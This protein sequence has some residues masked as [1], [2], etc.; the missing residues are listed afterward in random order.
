MSRGRLR[1]AVVVMG[2]AGVLGV[3]AMPA[4]AAT[5]ATATVNSPSADGAKVTATTQVSVTVDRG[6][7][8]LNITGPGGYGYAQSVGTANGTQTVTCTFDPRS[9]GC[10]TG[11][12]ILPN[13]VYTVTASSKAYSTSSGCGTLQTQSCS[14]AASSSPGRTFLLS[15]APAA[16]SGVTATATSS[17]DIRIAWS[18][19]DEPD[20][21]SYDLL[22]GAGNPLITQVTC[23]GSD[24]HVDLSYPDDDPGGDKDFRVRAWRS[25]GAGDQVKSA[26]SSTA[27]VSLPAPSTAGSGGTGGTDGGTSG[28]DPGTGGTGGSGGGSTGGSTSGGS[29]GGSGGIVDN[30]T[31]GGGTGTSGPTYS[32]YS[33]RPGLGLK[34]TTSGG[35]I[36]LPRLPGGDNPNPSVAI[37]EGTYGKTLGYQDQVTQDKVREQTL[38]TR[39]VTTF[40][41]FTD[42]DR[43]WKSLAGAL[44]LV[45]LGTHMRV[46]T[47]SASYE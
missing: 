29:S 32:G 16:P 25:D 31:S 38:S 15:A 23:A 35:G 40:S 3:G 12:A 14:Y 20:I 19:N 33:G 18:P 28:T 11:T 21:T 45:L 17:R 10:A 46:W 47:R 39:L 22:D 13:G 42:G 6:G 27:S 30:G 5:T 37:P 2:A 4:F 44:I 43:I 1:A 34:F 24:C 9:N 8:S 26:A 36:V 7:G 41:A